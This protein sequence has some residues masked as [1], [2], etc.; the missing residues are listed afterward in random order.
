MKV[1]GGQIP[2]HTLSIKLDGVQVILR[3]GV[4]VS[5]SGT[6]LYN[7]DPLYLEDGKRYEA[8]L[9]SFKET[10]SVL[11]THSHARKVRKDELYEISPAT[12]KRLLLPLDTGIEAKFK[13]IVA[14][15]G[16]GLV[17]DQTY[18]LKSAETHDVPI[19]AIIP[20]KGRHAGRMGA[21]MTSRGKVGTGFKDA[22][23]G[24]DWA[25]RIG[26]LIEVECMEI[27]PSGKFR[28]PRYVR[29]RWDKSA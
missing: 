12:D 23:R 26:H 4:V 17:I 7:V 6:K 5:R 19:L 9:G 3:D 29:Y 16:E 2:L 11:R 14:A 27:M 25:A 22:E 20:G 13:A 18:K 1:W 8:Y 21:L 24:E 15:G 10:N 28:M